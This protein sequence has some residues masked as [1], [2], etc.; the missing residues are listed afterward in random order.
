MK[1]RI[2]H[3]VPFD[4]G[5][6]LMFSLFIVVVVASSLLIITEASRASHA[7]MMWQQTQAKLSAVDES[8]TR[9]HEETTRLSS[10]E[11]LQAIADKHGLTYNKDNIKNVK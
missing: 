9:L 3:R 5:D 7:N 6:Y 1:L 11:R 4:L 2:K 10:P 8:N